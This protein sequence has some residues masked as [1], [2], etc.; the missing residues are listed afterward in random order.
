MCLVYSFTVLKLV[1]KINAPQIFLDLTYITSIIE[2][3][4]GHMEGLLQ[5]QLQILIIGSSK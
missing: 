4:H 1:Q 5:F 2:L 3:Y